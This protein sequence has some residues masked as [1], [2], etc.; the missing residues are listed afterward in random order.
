SGD[1]R[2]KGF[3]AVYDLDTDQW[4][5]L[6]AAPPRSH[7]TGVIH[8]GNLVLWGGFQGVRDP[9]DTGKI[10][11]NGR[12]QPLSVENAPSPRGGHHSFIW[13]NQM[14]IWGGYANTGM[15]VPLADGAAY[16]FVK[17]AWAP[18]DL[19]GAPPPL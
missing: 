8:G 19:D 10:L 12:W 13:H 16:D 11:V 4:Q 7:H 2:P 9:V 6:P 17:G 14:V 1:W 5:P 18:L 15:S 3:G